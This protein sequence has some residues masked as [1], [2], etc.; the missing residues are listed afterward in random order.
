MFYDAL[1]VIGAEV[2][3]PVKTAMLLSSSDTAKYDDN[4]QQ[5]LCG[6]MLRKFT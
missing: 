5:Q 4:R 1:M 3:D 2:R 6:A